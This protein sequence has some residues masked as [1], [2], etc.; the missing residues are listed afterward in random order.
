MWSQLRKRKYRKLSLNKHRTTEVMFFGVGVSC[1][2]NVI[3]KN[4]VVGSGT[5][6][7]NQNDLKNTERI[8][9]KLLKYF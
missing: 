1:S 2:G 7:A 5:I 8:R 3:G 4:I 6:N 9:Q